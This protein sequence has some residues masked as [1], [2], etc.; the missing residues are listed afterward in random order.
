MNEK[1]IAFCFL[2]LAI[3]GLLCF[4]YNEDQQRQI[5]IEAINKQNKEFKDTIILKGSCIIDSIK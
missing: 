4:L 1:K 3:F 2:F 5:D